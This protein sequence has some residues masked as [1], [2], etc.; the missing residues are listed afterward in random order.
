MQR[1]V[2]VI[3]VGM[4]AFSPAVLSREPTLLVGEVLAQTLADA[5]LSA[6]D[7]GA[8]F[9]ATGQM[10]AERLQ[11]ALDRAG[12]AALPLSIQA[13][14]CAVLFQAA[15]AVAL[16]QCECALLLGVQDRLLP[17]AELGVNLPLLA[18]TAREYMVRYRARGETLA[19]VAVKARQHASL[20]P[21]A[22]FQQLLSL[23]DV[24]QAPVIAEPLTQP[25][26]AWA[27]S[28]VAAVLLCSDPVARRAGGGPAIRVLAQARVAPA[29]VAGVDQDRRFAGSDYEVSVA[30]A[31]EL[32]ERAGMGPQEVSVCEL[33][34]SSTIGE[35]LLYE[36]LGLCPEGGA[37]KMVEDGDNT[38]GG[39]L[40]VNPSGGLLSLGQAPAVNGL[41]Q[42]IELVG[43]L[44]GT[45]GQRQVADAQIALQHQTGT[46]GTVITTLYQRA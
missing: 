12:L 6:T 2:N 33:H 19:M 17:F 40:V 28:G 15:E 9:A 5:G 44:R 37:E 21:L 27:S 7:V 18:A 13:D 25:Q 46:D 38:Y 43:Q 8:V 29:Q 30:A 41:V 11:R 4:S 14:S 10:D 32:Y 31:R 23:D 35:L 45:L 26:L 39:N 3:G 1:C 20:N 22:A 16:G 24:L 36:A 34:D 42:C